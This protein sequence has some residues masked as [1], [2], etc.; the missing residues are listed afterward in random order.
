MMHLVWKQRQR[1]CKSNNRQAMNE[2]EFIRSPFL[3]VQRK[4]TS[5][6]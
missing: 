4:K 6:D 5:V 1:S 2:V 3:V